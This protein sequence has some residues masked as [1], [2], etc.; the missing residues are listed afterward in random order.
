MQ[1]R[2]SGEGRAAAHKALNL[3]IT[4]PNRRLDIGVVGNVRHDDVGMGPNAF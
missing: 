4:E 3:Y 1:Q 2:E